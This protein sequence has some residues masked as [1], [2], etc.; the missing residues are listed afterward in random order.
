MEYMHFVDDDSNLCALVM[1]LQISHL[2]LLHE[3]QKP[4][5]V[6]SGGTLALTR[7]LFKRFPFLKPTIGTSSETLLC[8]LSGV[9]RR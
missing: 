6:L 8:S 4:S 5:S 3:P 7:I 9:R 1:C 2:G